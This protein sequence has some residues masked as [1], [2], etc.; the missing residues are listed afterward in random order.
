MNAHD[1][2]DR[3]EDKLGQMRIDDGEP[4][5]ACGAPARTRLCEGLCVVPVEPDEKGECEACGR[6]LDE[7]GRP[8]IADMLI[9]LVRVEPPPTADR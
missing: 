5:E 3:L 1:R 9:H 8:L 4:C 2:L 6:Q 7:N